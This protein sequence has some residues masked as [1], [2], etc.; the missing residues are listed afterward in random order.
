MRVN[1]YKFAVTA[2][3]IA[4]AFLVVRSVQASSHKGLKGPFAD[5]VSVTKACLECH[6]EAADEVMQTAHWQWKG[7]NPYLEGHKGDNLGKINLINNF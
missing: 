3:A 2:L 7:P 1:F 4:S 5:G 6:E